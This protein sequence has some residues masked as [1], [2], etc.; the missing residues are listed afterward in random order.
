[1]PIPLPPSHEDRY[2]SRPLTRSTLPGIR[3]VT[4]R[5][6]APNR[7]ERLSEERCLTA[8]ADTAEAA[9]GVRTLGALV[10]MTHDQGPRRS[11]QHGDPA[12]AEAARLPSATSAPSSG[13]HWQPPTLAA[14]PTPTDRRS[15]AHRAP[16]RARPDP[17]RTART[18]TRRAGRRLEWLQPASPVAA[19]RTAATAAEMLAGLRARLRLQQRGSAPSQAC[20]RAPAAVDESSARRRRRSLHPQRAQH[21]RRIASWTRQARCRALRKHAVHDLEISRSLRELHPP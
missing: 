2:S 13:C 8:N 21:P 1:M 4:A 10:P 12:R 18:R 14:T 16:R 3:W 6:A 7:R 11:R 15:T 9:G 20:R 5:E 19:A 17:D